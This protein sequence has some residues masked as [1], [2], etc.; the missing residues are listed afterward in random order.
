MI[1]DELDNIEYEYKESEQWRT[2][3]CIKENTQKDACNY[4]IN[5][6]YYNQRPLPFF[7]LRKIKTIFN[8][9]FDG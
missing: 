6:R 2:H 9:S 8:S 5:N 4:T 7:H 1:N 3:P